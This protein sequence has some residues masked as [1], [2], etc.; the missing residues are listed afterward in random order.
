VRGAENSDRPAYFD[1]DDGPHRR[2]ARRLATPPLRTHYIRLGF[3]GQI[4]CRRPD[5]SQSQHQKVAETSV[6]STP[7]S[8]SGAL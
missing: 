5:L 4:N 7:R 6:F 1:R 2:N 3:R 8:M